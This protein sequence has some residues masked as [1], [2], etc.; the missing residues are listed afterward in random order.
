MSDPPHTSVTIDCHD[1]MLQGMNL[2]SVQS[3]EISMFVG[4]EP[5]NIE[6]QPSPE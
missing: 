1:H 2:N 4:G 6:V 5:C 3:A